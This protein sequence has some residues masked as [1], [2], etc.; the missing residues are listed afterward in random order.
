[1]KPNFH[2]SLILSL[3]FAVFVAPTLL[4]IFIFRHPQWLSVNTTNQGQLLRPA[5]HLHALEQTHTWRIVLWSPTPSE[6]T[7][8]TQ[9]DQLTR[10]RLALGRHFYQTRVS[11]LSPTP[12]KTQVLSQLVATQSIELLT[13]TAADQHALEAF[14]APTFFIADPNHAFILH[15]PM[16]SDLSA[17]FHDLKHLLSINPKSEPADAI[18][19][20]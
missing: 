17:I 1:M 11:L 13:P 10:V 7:C 12:I 3:L 18:E 4:G 15:Y 8:I 9:L 20:H 16:Q 5:I 2:N 6:S 19:I 14:N